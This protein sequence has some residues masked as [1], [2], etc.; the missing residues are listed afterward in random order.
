MFRNLIQ[1]AIDHNGRDASITVSLS[2]DD[3]WVEVTIHDD[4]DGIPVEA[5]ESLFSPPEAGDHGYGLFL[6]RNLIELY[7][8]RI[9]L[10]ET[11]AEGTE[12][13]VRLPTATREQEQARAVTEAS[14]QMSSQ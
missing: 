4:G 12:S 5:R 1:N 9:E 13:R 3:E 7:G 6:T 10:T 2:V 11:G 8:G 14:I